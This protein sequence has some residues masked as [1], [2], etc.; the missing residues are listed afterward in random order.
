MFAFVTL[1]T[2]QRSLI[3]AYFRAYTGYVDVEGHHLFFYFFESRRDPATG[4]LR[5]RRRASG[6]LIIGLY[7]DDVMMWIN[8][9]PGC[10][11]STGLLME[12]G[13]SFGHLGMP[14]RV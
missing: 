2:W 7:A 6:S 14:I 5:L 13:K 3:L 4:E 8:G 10:S 9:G 11:A 12:L 1:A